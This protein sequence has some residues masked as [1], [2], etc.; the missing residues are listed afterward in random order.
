[1]QSTFTSERIK[2]NL[3]NLTINITKQQTHKNIYNNDSAVSRRVF[4]T[5]TALCQGPQASQMSELFLSHSLQ[6]GPKQS[7]AKL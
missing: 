5:D 6:G 2:R 4:G 1:M 3:F 7:K